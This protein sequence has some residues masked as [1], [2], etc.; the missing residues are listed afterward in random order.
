MLNMNMDFLGKIKY[1]CSPRLD[2]EIFRS[3]IPEDNYPRLF[4]LLLQILE[5]EPEK[6]ISTEKALNYPFFFRSI[7]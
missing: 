5:Y 2:E 1:N 3:T 4:D 7:R 6:R